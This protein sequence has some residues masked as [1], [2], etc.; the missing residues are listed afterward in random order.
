MAPKKW[1]KVPLKV[2][3]HIRVLAQDYKWKVS[4]IKAQKYPNIPERT[5]RYHTKLDTTDET[6]D[7]RQFNSGRPRILKERDLRRMK[8]KVKNLRKFDDPNFSAVKL[9]EVCD[10]THCSMRT[11]HRALKNDLGVQYLNT[12]QKG[13]LSDKDRKLRVDFCKRCLRLVG[14]KLWLEGISFYY[15][16]VSFYHKN[17]PFSDAVAPKAKIWRKRGEGLKLTTKGKK[18]GNCGKKVMLFVAIA[19]GKGVVM[20]EQFDPNIRF[21]GANYRQFVVDNFPAT[22]QRSTNPR[23]KLVLQ[24]GCPVQKSKQANLGYKAVGCTIFSIP[25]RSPDLNPIENIFNNVR[26]GLREEAKLK[27]I[28][29]ESYEEFTT[30][31]KAAICA[32]SHE[33][34]DKTISSLPRRMRAVIEGHGDRTKY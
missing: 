11:V 24:D 8:A 7:H 32:T 23:K 17:N 4:E 6:V 12:R 28:E 22:L 21:I 20:C 18:E 31:I 25:A 26:R 34:I 9:R 1:N 27:R 14:D 15:D 5:I 33:L 19:Y 10:L 13:I 16:G 2:S 3:M 29:K 30:R